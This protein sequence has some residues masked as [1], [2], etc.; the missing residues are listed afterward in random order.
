MVLF[1][2]LG[3]SVAPLEIFLPTLLLS[4]PLSFNDN[5]QS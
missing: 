5:P 2:G 3:F 1:F 4:T